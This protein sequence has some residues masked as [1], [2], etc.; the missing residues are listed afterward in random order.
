MVEA[1]VILLCTRS[2]AREMQGVEARLK[3]FSPPW[4]DV[5]DIAELQVGPSF[6]GR[7]GFRAGFGLT[8]VKMFRVD[9][10]PAYKTF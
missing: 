6:S 7:A 3:F 10:G 5:V 2:V 8:F 4:N 9:F 1:N